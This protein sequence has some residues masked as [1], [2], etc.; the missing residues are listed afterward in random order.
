MAGKLEFREKLAGI[1]EFCKK[2]DNQI[3]KNEVE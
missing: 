1:L 2:K 3:E